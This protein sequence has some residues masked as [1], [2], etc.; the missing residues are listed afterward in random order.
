MLA[1][2]PEKHL[3]VGRTALPEEQRKSGV[4]STLAAGK[5]GDKLTMQGIEGK[6]SKQ[7]VEAEAQAA[8]R[9]SRSP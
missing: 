5:G 6:K 8:Y 9:P 7:G 3:W 1:N 4:A 2:R